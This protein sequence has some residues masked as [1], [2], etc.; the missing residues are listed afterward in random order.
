[1]HNHYYFL[2][3]LLLN[4]SI[5]ISTKNHNF[6]LFKFTCVVFVLLKCV[7]KIAIYIININ[8]Y[9][10]VIIVPSLLTIFLAKRMFMQK[11]YILYH[12]QIN[13]INAQSILK[14][15]SVFYR[16]K[17]KNIYKWHFFFFQKVIILN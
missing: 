17:K 9:V 11:G 13:T 3:L 8:N 5:L 1:M 7:Q 12:I 14:F 15:R 4:R 16:V 10:I 6:I 2:V